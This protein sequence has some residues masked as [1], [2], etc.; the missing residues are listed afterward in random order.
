MPDSNFRGGRQSWQPWFDLHPPSY[1]QLA[2]VIT[3]IDDVLTRAGFERGP[4]GFDAISED[5]P[6]HMRASW[7]RDPLTGRL[8]R[9]LTEGGGGVIS[10]VDNA[11]VWGS[12]LVRVDVDAQSIELTFRGTEPETIAAIVAAHVQAA[13]APYQYRPGPQAPHA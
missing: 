2:A 6:L 4:F 10:P 12:G 8:D 1:E 13:D 9:Q 3:A 11:A 5:E 7:T